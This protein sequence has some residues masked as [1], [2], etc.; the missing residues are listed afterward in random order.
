MSNERMQG[1]DEVLT[2]M[3]KESTNV[4]S[5]CTIPKHAERGEKWGL[6][7]GSEPVRPQK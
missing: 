7:I 1:A 3:S 4:G 5:P 2:R 6:V